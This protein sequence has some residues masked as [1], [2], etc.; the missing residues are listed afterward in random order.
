LTHSDIGTGLHKK[1]P[2]P[3]CPICK[4]TGIIEGVKEH[5]L[6]LEKTPEEYVQHLVEVFR[7]VKRVLRDDG[8]LW[9]NL[10]DC[11]YGSWGNSG[12]REGGQREVS[13]DKLD[14]TA[15]EDHT[16][17]PGSSFRHELL[18]PKDLVGIPWAVAFAL[19]A[20]GWYLRS[21][22]IWNKP[23]PMPES[24]TD[25]PTKSHEYIFL[26]VK[27]PRYFYD[28]EAIR[29]KVSD[30][31]VERWRG[32]LRPHNPAH[33]DSEQS[34]RGEQSLGTPSAGRNKRSVWTM[35]TKPYAEAHFATFPP[36]LPETCI[37]AGTSQK[38][39]C[40]KCGAPWER[41][42]ER[43][44]PSLWSKGDDWR[45]WPTDG[46]NTNTTNPQTS[47]SLHRQKGGV[48]PSG[49]FLG[50]QPT[51]ECGELETIPCI[52]L[53]PFAGSGT[54]GMVAKKLGRSA[55][56]I[57]LNPIYIDMVGIRTGIGVK[58]GPLDRFPDDKGV[59]VCQ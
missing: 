18:K 17:R 43:D 35:N 29:E 8:T 56:L 16:E 31:S 49:K 28:Q 7:E 33:G 47:K 13:T 10:G 59:F 14:R 25:R 27:S 44:N 50:W 21:D 54:T 30:A 38:G 32:D 19:Q 26:L 15:W 1:E 4:G 58:E 57:E 34:V 40:P 3:N 6:G 39:C 53:D 9:L 51:C 55:I 36:E 37:K 2:N 20:D 12:S 48:Y 45:G 52:V 5:Q 46:P 24:V 22:I 11:Y 23:N 41:V 42:I